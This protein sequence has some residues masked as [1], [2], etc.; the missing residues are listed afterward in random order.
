MDAT[1]DDPRVVE[2][3]REALQNKGI[4]VN[5]PVPLFPYPGSGEYENLGSPDDEAWERAAHIT[6][7]LMPGLATFRKIIP[8]P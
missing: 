8:S 2:T 7:P 6:S 5:R 4:W 1:G 3:W